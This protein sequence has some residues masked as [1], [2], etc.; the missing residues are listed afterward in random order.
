[1]AG[2]KQFSA[3]QKTAM[4]WWANPRYQEYDAI[5]C[6]GAVRSGK[7]LSMGMGFF[8]WAM[9]RFSG[10]QFALCGKTIV[11]LRRNVL[12][13]I[14][15]K[16]TALGFHCEEKRS[17]NLVIV[18]SGGR[19][20]R[21][22]LFGGNDEG[23]AALI[24]GVT[25][26]GVLFDEAAL[27]PR[28]FVEQ[29][30]AR[31]SVSG[32]KL[33]FNCNPEG[34]QHWFRQEWILKAEEHK[35]LHLHFTME[36]NPALDEATRARYR[37]MYYAGV[38]YQRYILGLWVMSEGLIYDMFDQT[39]NVYRTQERPVDLEW[40]S[41]RTVACDYGTANPTVF[42]DIYDHDGVIRVD[43]EYRWD[44]RKERRQKTDQEYADDLLDFLGREWCAVIVDPSAAS[45]IEE[46]RRRGVYVIP[47]EN[48]VLDGI[49]K[50]GSLFHRRKILV[51]EACAGLLD[52]LGT[53]LWDEKAG[54]R[55]D[56]K[57]LK[58]RD[59]GPD[60]LRY[61]INSLPDWRFE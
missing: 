5:I 34:P 15:P 48:E 36:D 46:L 47:A 8:L 3:K 51:S 39:E 12:H 20:N 19:E 25:L 14:L 22:Y 52:E 58:E 44:S 42:L 32:S 16:V 53:Y 40:V 10:E 21:F 56:E 50:T 43:R 30:S 2:V 54:Q 31:C 35:A 60:A 33:W 9:R 29:A 23:S 26:A 41:Q 37:S 27:M 17:E 28:S 7:T 18:R 6:D 45:F 57:P 61:Y 59:H 49:R 13:E 1:M 4:T 38:F 24:Q 55:G 11:S